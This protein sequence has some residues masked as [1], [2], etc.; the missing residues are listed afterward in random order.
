MQYDKINDYIEA[1]MPDYS[2]SQLVMELNDCDYR[3]ENSRA[4]DLSDILAQ[5]N[6]L[7]LTILEQML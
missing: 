4:N 6:E 5:R 7:L 3:L 1:N 2:S